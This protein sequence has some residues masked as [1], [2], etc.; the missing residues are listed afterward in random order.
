MESGGMAGFIV[1]TK[2]F[3]QGLRKICDDNDTLL[4]FDEVCESRVW[5]RGRGGE[6]ERV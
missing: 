5:V 1:P 2:E 6:E 4:V 3:L